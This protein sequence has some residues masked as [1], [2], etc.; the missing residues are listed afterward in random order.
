MMNIIKLFFAAIMVSFAANANS[1][2][3]DFTDD[4]WQ[5]NTS[6]TLGGLTASVTAYNSN[7]SLTNYSSGQGFD[8]TNDSYCLSL[9]LACEIDG[10]GVGDDEITYS[11]SG[12]FNSAERIRV[13]FSETVNINFALF[14]D[15]FAAGANGSD[16]LTESAKAT[17]DTN[18]GN[19]V[20]DGIALDNTGWF[21]ATETNRSHGSG[22]LLGISYAEF[23]TKNANATS[24]SDFALAA[25]DVSAVVPEPSIIALFGA[26]ILGLGFAR[27][28]KLR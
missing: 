2:L 21:M 11:S 15:L 24:N 22:T 19:L 23:F 8:G 26:G 9:S 10:L 28:R 27:R 17:G 5:S 18:N 16:P 25:L 20:W 3:F 7:G 4:Y 14:L 13:T 1:A 6:M 12:N